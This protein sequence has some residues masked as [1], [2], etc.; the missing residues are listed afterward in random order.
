MPYNLSQTEIAIFIAI[1]IFYFILKHLLRGI[2]KRKKK[3]MENNQNE[4]VQPVAQENQQDQSVSVVN[5]T[6]IVPLDVHTE[7]GNGV[8]AIPVVEFTATP[9]GSAEVIVPTENVEV[10]PAETTVLPVEEKGVGLFREETSL[11]N[12]AELIEQPAVEPDLTSASATPV[13]VPLELQ[14]DAVKH[15]ITDEPVVQ[16]P[17]IA[18]VAVCSPERD[19]QLQKQAAEA[20]AST[21]VN[22]VAPGEEAKL[23]K[24]EDVDDDFKSGDYFI[25]S[26]PSDNDDV[27]Y[28]REV[29]SDYLDSI[30][31]SFASLQYAT[32]M[33]LELVHKIIR[34]TIANQYILEA[35]FTSVRPTES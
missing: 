28:T 6:P 30:I 21:S 33:D 15:F 5:E 19:L 23:N 1:V 26:A 17:S 20:T 12:G 7:E 3:I 9:I 16:S 34:D 4:N 32:D 27:N 2:G 35:I 25:N 18:P 14:P 13:Q 31:E 24:E 8:E 29:T 22:E 11:P 10:E